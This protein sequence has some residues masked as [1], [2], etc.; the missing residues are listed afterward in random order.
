MSEFRP[1]PKRSFNDMDPEDRGSLP[2]FRLDDTQ[3]PEIKDWKTGE[4]YIITVKVKQMGSEIIEHGNRKGG[5][6]NDFNVIEIK[7]G[8]SDMKNE[9][10]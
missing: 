10:M 5:L 7:A 4:E 6:C 9:N 8:S 3:L 1:I 2:S